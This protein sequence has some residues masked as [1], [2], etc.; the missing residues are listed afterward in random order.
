L[1]DG[2][3]VLCL[4]SLALTLQSLRYLEDLDGISV[5]VF[6]HFLSS[7]GL[8]P[9]LLLRL[10]NLPRFILYASTVELL[11]CSFPSATPRSPTTIYR[12]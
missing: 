8:L 4:E 5:S 1:A 7:P 3:I 9:F 10:V 12:I 6:G 11:H 2:Q